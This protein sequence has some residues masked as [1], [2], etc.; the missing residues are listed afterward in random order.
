MTYFITQRKFIDS[1]TLPLILLY[2]LA[3][4]S[5]LVGCN[6]GGHDLVATLSDAKGLKAG[7]TVEW[8]GVVV[9][10]VANVT[11]GP[12]GV[13]IRIDIHGDH[14][15]NIRAGASASA[16]KSMFSP[17]TKLRIYG[18]RDDARPPLERGDSL[19]QARAVP[20]EIPWSKIAIGV[21]ASLIGC[22]IVA[23]IKSL[24]FLTKFALV[25]LFLLCGLGFLY[26]Q[27][28]KYKHDLVPESVLVYIDEVVE[29]TIRPESAELWG[30]IRSDV[31]DAVAVAVKQGKD[32]AE[33][34]FEVITK[35]VQDAEESGAPSDVVENIKEIGEAYEE[36]GM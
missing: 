21:F 13:V 32:T 3:L 28:E 11:P 14:L 36:M 15:K 22:L 31:E 18:G 1:T 5:T 17:D 24:K 19:P 10:E 34:A 8:Q 35:A 27:W 23:L 4:S 30:V 16:S 9:G 33:A 20:P 12:Q 26:L 2:V 25:T 29:K 6:S 7:D